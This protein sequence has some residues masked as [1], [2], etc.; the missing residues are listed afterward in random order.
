M[1]LSGTECQ[2]YSAMNKQAKRQC[3]ASFATFLFWVAQLR[4]DPLDIVFHENVMRFDLA[5]VRDFLADVMLGL[6]L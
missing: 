4:A 5:V 1:L 3:G 6:K 2:E